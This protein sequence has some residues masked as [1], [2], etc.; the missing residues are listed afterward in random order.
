[1]VKGLE[2][3][4]EHFNGQENKYVIIGG[5]ACDIYLQNIGIDFRATKDLD[6]VLIIE[7]AASTFARVFWD[8]IKKGKY[9]NIQKSTGRKMYYRFYDPEEKSFPFML[10]LFS[11]VPDFLLFDTGREVTP[12]SFE[13]E[14]SS[15]SAILLENDYYEFIKEGIR[16]IDG[17]PILLPEYLIPLKAKAYLDLS[18]K[19][20]Q[21]KDID[22]KDITK[23][24]NDVFRLYPALSPET[25][26]KLPPLIADDINN[27]LTAMTNQSINLKQ[28]GISTTKLEQVLAQLK[29]IYLKP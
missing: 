7:S 6:M 22:S 9:K 5:T 26:V 17:L 13:D 11:R 1:M 23:H 16:I 19:K 10:E 24:R 27:F 15:L 20:L 25:K 2:L 8:F 18:D 14:A 3:F 12:I 28:F 4:R 29:D 21:G